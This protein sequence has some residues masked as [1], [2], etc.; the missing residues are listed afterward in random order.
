[1]SID[2][3]QLEARQVEAPFKPAVKGPSDFSQ[4]DPVF[5]SETPVDTYVEPSVLGATGGD[6]MFSEFTYVNESAL[7]TGAD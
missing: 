2:W 7:T 3:V 5:T 6:D 4:I 1:A